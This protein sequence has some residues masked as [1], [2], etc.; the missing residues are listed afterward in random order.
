[1]SQRIEDTLEREGVY[2]STTVGSSMWPMLR[3]RRDTIVIRP[4]SGSL[5]RYE[6][7]LFRRGNDY[8]LHR[9]VRVL[10]DSYVMCGDNCAEQE[11]GVTDDQI[12]GVLKEFY[13]GKRRVRHDARAY[14]AYARIWC[15]FYPLRRVRKRVLKR[16]AR[17][18]RT[19][20]CQRGE[21]G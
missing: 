17:K 20:F 2:V 16:M 9:V 3:N 5:S 6:V 12:V 10:P 19:L 11:L 8:V 21:R 1:M 4:V 18:A 7:P 14:R 13:R 15:A